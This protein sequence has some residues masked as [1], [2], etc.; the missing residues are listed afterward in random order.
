MSKIQE[1]DLLRLSMILEN[2]GETTRNKYIC[3]LVEC[4]LFDSTIE[5]LSV[6]DLRKNILERFQLDFDILEI[7]SAIRQRGRGR[8][9]AS[10]KKYQLEPKVIYQLSN[11]ISM[12]DRLR[13]FVNT[14]SDKNGTDKEY[15]LNLIKKYLYYCFNSNAKNFTTII[16]ATP[17]AVVDE[18]AL[19]EFQPTPSEVELIN[20]FLMWDNTE[21]NKLFYAI[22]SCCYEYCLITANKQPSISHKLF[23][24]KKFFFDT[25]IIFRMAGFNK[26][27]RQFVITTF[28]D[29]CKEVGIALCYTNI[30]YDEINR[31]I[32][33]QVD[34]IKRLSNGQPPI[35]EATLSKI[36][37]KADV[38][39]FY[40]IYYNWCKEPQNK[41]YDFVS[42][43]HYL[44]KRVNA[45][46][47]KLDYIDCSNAKFVDKHAFEEL[48]ASLKT[49]KDT[50]RNNR[51]T[52]DES[53]E[54]DIN[55]VLHLKKVRPKMAKSLWEMNEYLVSTDQL[56]VSWANLNFNGVPLVV[57][58]SLWLSII[59]KITGRAS[60]NDY[61][62]FCMFL[63]LR[64]HQNIEDAININPIELLRRLAEKTINSNLKEQIIEEITSNK[65]EYTFDA[66][67]NYDS[68]IDK[69]FDVILSKNN[70]LKENELKEAVEREKKNAEKYIEEYRKENEATKSN[71]NFAKK[72]S[73][74][75]ATKKTKWFAQRKNIP[76]II[77]ATA[78]LFA[79]VFLICSLFKIGP[80]AQ[81]MIDLINSENVSDK[82][83]A[84]VL[85]AVELFAGTIWTYLGKV[86]EYLS[87]EERKEKLCSRY[88]KQ[89]L[90][91]LDEKQ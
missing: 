28:V 57:I 25:N 67:T 36:V 26:D 89:Q 34:Y 42:F 81:Y 53:V 38:N 59:L 65:D 4:V 12:E 32:D 51:Y 40:V 9:I 71:E 48:T 6:V 8:I 54:T 69:A 39:D 83:L 62:S 35:S 23:K 1:S 64:Q 84:V 85:C 16:G 77:D 18:N 68:S 60:D 72:F 80:V 91:I 21:K 63:T 7:E 82:V 55:Q 50:K 24:G 87:S 10:N 33:R 17:K 27:E 11:R 86:W 44:R 31:V 5:E 19:N 3:K 45:E 79:I 14:F 70:E 20:Q 76:L 15:L 52:T 66:L 37:D 29:K 88:M 13:S 61:K 22:V 41:Y 75:K 73:L 56:F 78:F 74:M 43:K 49:Y 90:K 2:Q 47:Q 30:V 58:P 46:L